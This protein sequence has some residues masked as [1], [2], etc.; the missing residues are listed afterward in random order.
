MVRSWVVA[1]LLAAGCG[2]PASG[3][4]V[5]G[6]GHDPCGGKDA[7]EDP[8]EALLIEHHDVVGQGFGLLG[9]WSALDGRKIHSS[10]APAAD[11]R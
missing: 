10:K 3:P 11:P 8:G 6:G 4:E 2:P 1:V 7:K 9:I 5:A